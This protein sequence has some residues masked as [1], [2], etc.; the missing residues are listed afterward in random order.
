MTNAV[1]PEGNTVEQL[2]S[3]DTSLITELDENQNKGIAITGM[4]DQGRG[5]WQFKIDDQ[6]NGQWS[7]IPGVSPNNVLRLSSN[8]ITHIR[9]LPN[10]RC[11]FGGPNS[12]IYLDFIAW[13][14]T[15]SPPNTITN[16]TTTDPGQGGGTSA[17]SNNA[18][19]FFRGGIIAQLNNAQGCNP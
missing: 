16:G 8:S 2:I 11:K 18:N 4:D 1:D 19:K 3:I 13:D 10:G 12:V 9:F 6:N 5:T 7:N 14:Q 15:D 17:F